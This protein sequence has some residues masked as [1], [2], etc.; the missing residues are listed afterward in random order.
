MLPGARFDV[1]RW[2]PRV[3]EGCKPPVRA[4]RM[5][6]FVQALLIATL[7]ASPGHALSVKEVKPGAATQ[8]EAVVAPPP[9]P[10]PTLPPAYEEPMLRLSEILGSLHYLRELCG[11]KEGQMWRQQMEAMIASEEPNDSR[12]ALLIARFNRGF[13]GFQEIYRECTPS[14]AESANRYLQQGARLSAEIPGRY[15]N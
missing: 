4:L 6:L 1:A 15:G 14:A 13:R 10:V 8:G 11:A 3:Y 9:P 5:R 12:K 2:R 7:C